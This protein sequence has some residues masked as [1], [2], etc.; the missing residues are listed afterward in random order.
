MSETGVGV[1]D[2]TLQETNAWMKEIGATVGPEEHLQ[3]RALRSVLLALRDRLAVEDAFH[4]S[5][6]LPLLVRG[7][8]WESYRA[9]GKPED[10]STREAFL[11]R[12][13][14]HLEPGPPLDPE[15]VARAV[16]TAL[17]RHIP[18]GE[19]EHIRQ[20]L[21]DEVEE[22]FASSGI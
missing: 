20:L 13:S 1:F 12:V 5:A 10:Y 22:M 6:T 3:Y 21:P 16:F 11:E 17:L 4:L 15:Q 9:V 2:R 19:V 18:H 7:I 8:F 14:S